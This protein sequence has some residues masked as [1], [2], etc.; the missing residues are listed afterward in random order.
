[1]IGILVCIDTCSAAI[2]K[3]AKTLTNTLQ[4]SLTACTNSTAY[5]TVVGVAREID[6]CTGAIGFSAKTNTSST[7]TLFVAWTWFS[8]ICSSVAIVVLAIADLGL[9]VISRSCAIALVIALEVFADTVRLVEIVARATL[10]GRAVTVVVLAIAADLLFR[11]D[12]VLAAPRPLTVYAQF[13]TH[14]T[15]TF[16]SKPADAIG[17]TTVSCCVTGARQPGTGR[18]CVIVRC[19]GDLFRHRLAL[20]HTGFVWLFLWDCILWLVGIGGVFGNALRSGVWREFFADGFGDR[21]MHNRSFYLHAF[22]HIALTP[23]TIVIADT[24]SAYTTYAI[25]I[26][27]PTICMFETIPL[28]PTAMQPTEPQKPTAQQQHQQIAQTAH[29]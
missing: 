27:W 23:S 8:F 6:T 17:S 29:P 28:Y 11:L 12:L 21:F 26:C 2:H 24:L 22:A 19:F 18:R 15:D 5:T 4:A 13:H 16:A 25:L 3:I 14:P 10:V 7:D 9:F 20:R 1:V